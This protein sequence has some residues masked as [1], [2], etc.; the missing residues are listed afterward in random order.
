MWN[1]TRHLAAMFVKSRPANVSSSWRKSSEFYKPT[2]QCRAR[3]PGCV[4]MSPAWFQQA[5]EVRPREYVLKYILML[6]QNIPNWPLE[7][8]ASLKPKNPDQ[9]GHNWLS[10]MSETSA[11][12]SA[13]LRVMHPALYQSGRQT[14]MRLG[15]YTTL[16]PAL[17]L[18]PSVFNAV[19]VL[20][21]R[22]TPYHRDNYSR[23]QW[24]DI[25]TTVGPYKEA[26]LHFPGIGVRLAYKSGTVVGFSGKI[27]RHGVEECEGERVCLAYYMR[28]TVHE[29]MGVEAAQWMKQGCYGM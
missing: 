22:K 28:D 26:T 17:K 25:L 21:N 13:I 3:P 24:Y 18:W 1:A 10:E 11:L 2:D 9:G 7:I 29:R 4:D 8:S 20:S 15:Q 6:L 16:H 23:E 27:L 12:I 19:T 14:M 5:H